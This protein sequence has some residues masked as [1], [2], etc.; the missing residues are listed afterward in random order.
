[1]AGE[2]LGTYENSVSNQRV[3]IPSAY[4]KEFSAAAK[5][6]VVVTLGRGSSLVIYPYDKWKE[7]LEKLK[8]GD[9]NEKMFRTQLVF[10][11]DPKQK[12]EGPGRIRISKRLL[13]YANITK[14]VILSGGNGFFYLW[15]PG[16]Y[17]KY[18]D[19]LKKLRDETMDEMFETLL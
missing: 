5:Q 12:L 1:M 13:E 3:N 19:K 17:K 14:Q 2:F 7:I 18:E 16:N 4:K 6:T 11:A 15:S 10:W 8:N 9:R